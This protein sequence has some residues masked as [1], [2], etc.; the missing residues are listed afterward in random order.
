M[1]LRR[2]VP[3]IAFMAFILGIGLARWHV[4]DSFPDPSGG[5]PGNWLALGHGLIGKS[6][7]SASIVYPP[8]VPALM[9]LASNE[10]GPMLGA[11]ILAASA[12]LAPA[13]GTYVLMR[14]D[15]GVFAAVLAGLL[16]PA[17]S[18]GEAAAWG[19]YPQLL[20]LGL[21]GP[22][23]WSTG[24]FLDTSRLAWALCSSGFL[25]ATLATSDLIGAAAV[26]ALSTYWALRIA[27]QSKPVRP[28]WHKQVVGI[29]VIVG[30]ALLLAPL[31]MQLALA[32]LA[33]TSHVSGQAL[34][35]PNL[36]LYLDALFKDNRAVWYTA[37]AVA[38]LT[39]PLTYS[40][41]N[42]SLA[43]AAMALLTTTAAGTM[44]LRD[45]RPLYLLPV[46][47]IIGLGSCILAIRQSA[48]VALLPSS[49]LTPSI[50]FTD[51]LLSTLVAC[52]AVEAWLGLSMFPQ[53]VA[54]YMVLSPAIVTG[55]H[56][57]NQQ[58]P[59]SAAVAV[60]PGPGTAAEQGWPFGWWVEGLLDRPTYYAS[61][62]QWLN[63]SDELRR[64]A[65][66]DD[67]FGSG[68][69]ASG[70]TTARAHGISYLVICSDW[71]GLSRWSSTS[72]GQLPESKALGGLTVIAIPQH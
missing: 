12:S 34:G 48:D 37:T 63:F 21:V 68:G 55:L 66:A 60:S 13:I 69:E 45:I 14:R 64:A 57:L 58:I 16:A 1:T 70:I 3:D 7:R 62:P 33:H 17:A 42:N 2:I 23:F 24:R 46:A 41:P 71:P 65:V 40:S 54:Y 50:S 20:A 5:D 36:F 4:V 19:G 25:F 28:S 49:R 10:W 47:A 51:A 27:M 15:L 22:M 44:L 53:Q 67:I 61:A 26:A 9:L 11:K 30:P 29:A 31:Y 6:A 72:S 8:V 59:S 32:V 38:L 43:P 52:L 35:L 39:I 56:D 18:S